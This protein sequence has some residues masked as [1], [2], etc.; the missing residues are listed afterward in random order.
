M[1][2]RFIL[3][4]GPTGV[5]KSDTI[6][7]I[8][9]STSIEL[10][11]CD[12]GQFYEPVAIG[13]AKPDW[14]NE[15]IPHHL[16]DL[17]KEPKNFTVTAYRT[18]ITQTMKEIWGR[19]NTPVLV[20]GSGFYGKSLFFPPRGKE[21]QWD[22]KN[23]GNWDDLSKLDPERAEKIHK[24]DT[25]RIGRALSMLQSTNDKPSEFDPQFE[26][27]EGDCLVI[28]LTRDREQLYQRINERTVKMFDQ[29]W[30]QETE[31]LIGTP[32]ENFLERKKLIGY[33]DILQY[34]KETDKGEAAR[35]KVITTIAQ[36]TRHYA[37]RQGTFW[38]MFK[39]LLLPHFTNTE[40]DIVE[41]N[42]T[43]DQ[44]AIQVGNHLKKFLS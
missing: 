17:I 20:G 33:T 23:L 15:P 22:G 7:A 35:Q 43:Q 37:K 31:K 10:V 13:T 1:Q 16:F 27:L 3:V 38:R 41:V 4:H 5:G 12:V 6:T 30:V 24:N 14:Q 9:K 32:W 34:L 40:S 28:F 21:T 8:G 26:P 11:N 42:L 25:Y 19:G 44:K 18:M 2:N 29:G 39:K 36:K